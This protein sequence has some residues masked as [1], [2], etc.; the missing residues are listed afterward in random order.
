M[1]LLGAAGYLLPTLAG[2]A[3]AKSSVYKTP[4]NGNTI[5]V[6]LS[7]FESAN[8]QI[9]RPAGWYYDIAVHKQEDGSYTALLM[10][11]TH[12]DNQLTITGSGFNCSLHGSVFN[13]DGAV[14]KGPAERALQHYQTSIQSNQ[15]IITI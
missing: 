9:V 14:Q 8:L 4:I 6:P 12:M 2:C 1:C 5:S 13:K 15:L 3:T 11:C 10:K 7:L